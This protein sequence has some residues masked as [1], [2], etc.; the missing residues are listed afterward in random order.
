ML[1]QIVSKTFATLLLSTAFVT[2]YAQQNGHDHDHGHNHSHAHDHHH[3][4]DHDH[5]HGHSHSH[6]HDHAGAHQHGVGHLDAALEGQL[7]DIALTIPGADIVGFEH[8]PR[9][10]NQKQALVSAHDTLSAPNDMIALPTAAN[11]TAVEAV[12]ESDHGAADSSDN[13]HQ[14]A[15][16]HIHYQFECQNPDALA[17]VELTLFQHFE[18]LEQVQVQAVSEHSQVGTT[19][20]AEQ[21]AFSF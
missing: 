12:I 6:T 9:T 10:D 19:L 16:F 17:S 21:P 8:E 11:C 1:K 20:T 3:E 7:L 5:H 14:H 4:H 13:G 15:D 18:S 2:A